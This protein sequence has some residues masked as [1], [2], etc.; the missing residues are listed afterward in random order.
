MSRE[1]TTG[2]PLFFLALFVAAG[3]AL[4]QSPPQTGTMRTG[5]IAL[6]RLNTKFSA[7][8]FGSIESTTDSLPPGFQVTDA[9]KSVPAHPPT[10]TTNG[11]CLVTTLGPLS[12]PP[13]NTVAITV[14]DAGPV[15]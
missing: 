10:S 9:K 14:L 11:T 2:N 5:A 6:S 7:G 4:A 3:V 1:A 13:D 12:T 8:P 15:L